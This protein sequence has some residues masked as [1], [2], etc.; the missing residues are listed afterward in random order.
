MWPLWPLWPPG[1]GGGVYESRALLSHGALPP[2]AKPSVEQ[3]KF[4]FMMGY[5]EKLAGTG[6]GVLEPQTVCSRF[7]GAPIMSRN[8]KDYTDLHGPVEADVKG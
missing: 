5:T 8:P 2:I 1:Q 4:R 6:T 7:F 3:A